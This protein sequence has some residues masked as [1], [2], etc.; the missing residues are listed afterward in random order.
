MPS[1]IL[2]GDDREIAA[3]VLAAFQGGPAIAEEFVVLAAAVAARGSHEADART[4]QPVGDIARQ[5]EVEMAGPLRR[6]AKEAP[7]RRRRG[8]EALTEFRTDLIGI[9]G[10]AGADGGMDS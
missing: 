3:V 10:D 9:L 2:Q 7:V 6:R 8:E 1:S 5:V 4:A